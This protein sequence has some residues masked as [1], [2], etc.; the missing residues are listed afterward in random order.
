[1]EEL[2]EVVQPFLMAA[3]EALPQAPAP[4]EVPFPAPHANY[5]YDPIEPRIGGESLSWIYLRLICKYKGKG[6]LPPSN[7]FFDQAYSIFETKR[8]RLLKMGA[9]LQTGLNF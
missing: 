9:G 5:G 1:M 3:P 8:N 2:W 4:A 7:T 6:E